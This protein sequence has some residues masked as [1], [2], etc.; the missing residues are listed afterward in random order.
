MILVTAELCPY[1]AL[2]PTYLCVCHM[3][4]MARNKE[5]EAETSISIE[6]AKQKENERKS[7][8]TFAQF[9]SIFASPTPP[10][11]CKQCVLPGSPSAALFATMLQLGPSDVRASSEAV[12]GWIFF[13]ANVSSHR[14][15]QTSRE[16]LPD[17]EGSISPGTHVPS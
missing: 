2:P 12:H 11:I 5:K 7:T 8:T 14:D 15:L 16:S 1:F 9:R 3:S 10:V 6:K 13:D 4:S 17:C